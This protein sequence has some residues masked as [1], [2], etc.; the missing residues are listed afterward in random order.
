MI[1]LNRSQRLGLDIDRHIALD[2]GAGTGK[3]TVMAHRFIQHVLTADQRATR[4]LPIAPRIP[5]MGMGAIRCPASERTSISEWQ[6]L[7]PTEVVAI[8]F[9][10]KAAAELKGKIR[11]L[12]ANLRAQP[13]SPDDIE[14]VHD[15]RLRDQGDVEML[16]SLVDDASISTI[17]SFLSSL[18]SPWMGM[19]C[20]N[21]AT[22]QVDEDGAII[23]REEAI[24]TAWRLQR[25]IDGIEVGMSGDI[26]AFLAARDRLSVRLGGQ[27]SSTVVV[28]GMLKRSLF[29]EEAARRLARRTNGEL[30]ATVLDALFLTPVFDELDGFFEELH[31]YVYNWVDSWLAGGA[32]FITG[33]DVA[34]GQTRFRYIQHLCQIDIPTEPL[35]RLQWVWLV[36]HA[37][38]AETNLKHP[39]SSSFNNGRIPKSQGWPQGIMTKGANPLSNDVKDLII[40][41]A[42]VA[43]EPIREMLHSSIGFLIRNLGKASFLLNPLFQDPIEVPGQWA[44][45]PRLG[46]EIA[47]TPPARS[48]RLTTELEL[49]VMSDLFAVHEGVREILARLKSQEGVRDHDD[50]HRL[51]EDLL[52]ARCPAVCRSWYPVSVI[53]SLDSL[54]EEPWRDNHLVTAI[55][56]ASGNEEVHADLMRRITLL[57]DLRRSYRAFII[58]EYQDTNPQ[59]FRLL[60][61]LWGRRRLEESEPREPAGDWDP[62]ICI[63]GDMK[64]SIYRF[65]QAEVTVMRRAVASIRRVNCEEAQMEFR[66]NDLRQLDAARDPRPIPGAAG[67]STT[68]VSA[69]ELV[70][71]DAGREPWISFLLDDE[72]RTLGQEFVNRRREGHIEM[73]TN[74]RTLPRL[75]NTMNGIFQ[76]TFD[77]QDHQILPGPWHAEAQDLI[78]GREEG[79]RATF[80]WIL[81]TRL[82][83]ISRPADP[84]IAIDPFLHRGSSNRELGSDLLAKRISALLNGTQARVHSAANNAWVDVSEESNQVRPSDIMIL[85]SS[86]KRIPQLM[87][88]LES[89]GIP[90]MADKQGLLMHR[91]VVQPLM[92]LLWLLCSPNNKGAALAVARSSLVGMNDQEITNLLLGEEGNQLEAMAMNAPTTEVATLLFR[93]NNLISQGDV[94]AAISAAIEHSDLLYAYPREGDRQDVENWLSIYERVL[95]REG[96]DSALALS[97]LREYSALGNDGPKSKSEAA[98]GAVQIMTIHS[99]K[100]LEAPVVVLYDLFAT[101]SRDAQFSSSDNVLVTPDIIAGRIHPWRGAAKPQSGLWNLANLMDDGQQRAERRRQFYVGLTRARDRLI[102]VGVPSKGASINANGMVEFTRSGG[103]QNMGQ[104]FLDGMAHSSILAGNE[105][106]CWSNGGLNQYEAT[107]ALDPGEIIDE[108]FLSEDCVQ[109]ISIFHHPD[110]FATEPQISPLNRWVNRL[111]L[112]D[113]CGSNLQDVEQ[114]EMTFSVPLTSHSLDTASKCNRRHWLQTRLNWQAEKLSYVVTQQQSKNW[115]VRTEFGSLYHRLLEIG[116]PNPATQ[117]V[118][119]LDATWTNN[120][121]DYLDNSET[122]VEVMAQ[123]SIIDSDV[124]QRTRERLMHLATLVRNGALGQLTAGNRFDGMKIEGL[125]TE[126]PFFISLDHTPE[127]LHRNM[128]TPQ[129]SEIRA[130]VSRISTN[131]DGRVDLVLALRD[132]ENQGYLQVVDA[133][134]TGCLGEFNVDSPLEGSELQ[135]V[136]DD[137]SP[138]ATTPAEEN[139]IEEHRLQLALYSYALELSESLRPKEERRTIL[140]PAILVAA[141][142]RMIR[143]S[144]EQ[145]E[146]SLSDL[147]ELV[148]WMGIVAASDEQLDAPM[149][150]P[151]SEE[152]ICR[153]CPFNSGEIKICGPQNELLGPA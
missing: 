87:E 31:Q 64:Q 117:S 85:V 46:L 79:R 112:I 19:V 132:E 140:P 101:G 92:S 124:E 57:R 44:H 122:L 27:K 25:G 11:R 8:T 130:S 6:G 128:W 50:M 96:G 40:N 7:L 28:R 106:C 17:D 139:I 73:R 98:G 49:E 144:D 36:A 32:S 45:P 100:G 99:S 67:A 53:D 3:T 30:D 134:T 55:N 89:H 21:P 23:L 111:E 61:R 39:N 70:G 104:M 121:A 34:F 83:E 118:D 82:G 152:A 147:M 105:G 94:S 116:L 43:A 120:Q 88:S 33:A 113:N 77:N 110:C 142:G 66:T 16:L 56:A 123:S 9:T 69:S 18:V 12:I 65:R 71:E 114:R 52:L 86:R 60:A 41:S 143:M 90:A 97:R 2:A 135:I 5:L 26:E 153:K 131:F 136:V 4:L 141:S 37:A 76:D 22:E 80:E 102:L 108:S 24:R 72:N 84:E 62:T 133:K 137:N 109:G 20:E 48:S 15:T 54:G 13:P 42:R 115:P 58:D 35:E 10:R 78:P 151:M 138:F 51:A 63:V 119:D 1:N 59:H 107:L 68:F 145:F 38:T 150:L 127:N 29:V 126:L 149:R 47:Q 146:Q 125:R 91:P 103:R 81:P 148:Q 95:V 93:M 75:L 74:H 14:G 129:G